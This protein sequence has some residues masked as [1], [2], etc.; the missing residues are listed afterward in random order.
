M[1][2][3]GLLCLA[4]LLGACSPEP[5]GE[6]PAASQ[7]AASA[8]NAEAPA[9]IARDVIFGNAERSLARISPDGRH[10]SWLAPSD[11]VMNVWVA[12]TETPEQARAVTR[13]DYRGIRFYQ[14]APNSEFIYYLQDDGGD[15][16][17]HVYSANIE[18]GD[19]VD[20]TPVKEGARA[21]IQ[22]V[23]ALQPD[24]IVV[25]LNER[26]PQRF[27]LYR[28]DVTTGERELLLENPGYAAWLIDNE[29]EPRF[30]VETTPEGGADIVRFDGTTLTSIPP[31]DFLTTNS[32][33]F[34]KSNDAVFMLDS[35]GRDKA[36][37]TRLSVETGETAVIAEDERADITGVLIDNETYE[38]VAYNVDYL[39]STWTGL[40][41]T[42]ERDLEAIR[43]NLSGSLTIVAATDD[44]NRWVIAED[45]ADAPL[46]YVVYDRSERSVT[47]MLVTRPELADK[48]L[49]PMHPVVIE[50]R[51][52]LDLVSYLS[53]PPGSDADGDGRPEQ[54]LP[55]VL[56]VHG[57]PWARDDY[58]YHPWHQWLA[59]RGYAVLS[60]NYRGSTG[61]GKNFVRAAI[62]EFAGKMHDDLID[63][64]NWAVEQNV[65]Q[66]DRIA[67][68]GGS[69]GGYATLIGVSFTPDT[70]ACGVDIVGPSSLV[71]LI[72]SFPEY[73]KPFLA[74]TWYLYVGNPSNEAD[75]KDML[76]RSA[77]SRVDDI[78]VPLLVGQGENDPRVTKLESDQLVAAMDENGLPVTYVNFPDEGHGF[79]RPENR[80]AFYAVMEG[81]LAECLGG[82]AEPIGEAFEDSTIQVLHGPDYV[83]G[84]PEALA[85]DGET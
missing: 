36:A 33:G 47:P 25:G 59:N 64:V 63:G 11:G 71:T 77:I 56:A 70:F 43:A 17:F 82:R 85:A 35:R 6:P 18:T 13:D 30:G 61:F 16:N 84:L 20:L 37:L 38:P 62:R 79:A 41:D 34:N 74:G 19:V 75:H 27:D 53:L 10:V 83:D 45:E 31:E 40:D 24:H 28:I 1:K 58:G 50:S 66:P 76:S 7:A 21:Q 29:L 23:S 68:A 81:F 69:Y 42:L 80:L 65:A 39:K 12:P 48:E 51:D 78:R 46:R 57:G 22:A 14:W 60:V 54:P 3:T 4:V 32:I 73:W 2:S 5:A 67:I 15:E 44:M 26:D 49:A 72:E 9:L 8:A 52:G 55:M